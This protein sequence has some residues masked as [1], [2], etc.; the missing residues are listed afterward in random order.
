MADVKLFLSCVSDE[1]GDYRGALRKKLKRLNVEIEI[2]ETFKA[3]GGDT[4]A[5]LEEYIEGC[6]VVVHFVGD[7][8]GSPPPATSVDDLL[9]RRPDLAERLTKKG[10]TREE[11]GRLTYTQWEAWLAIGF[12]EVG[13]RKNLVIVRPSAGLGR[14]DD[15]RNGDS[16]RRANQIQR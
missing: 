3:R 2:Q 8:L 14:S 1:F 4:L 5:L 12:N 16:Q 13:K 9:N 11:L 10:L 6:D 7:M 15:L